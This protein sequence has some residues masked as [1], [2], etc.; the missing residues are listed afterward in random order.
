M[1][2]IDF[3]F[4][5]SYVLSHHEVETIN[6]NTI[7]REYGNGNNFLQSTRICNYLDITNGADILTIISFKVNASEFHGT[8][9]FI[10]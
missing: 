7:F 10:R 1:C 3:C 4:N 9:T 2:Q 6:I 8:Y 5:C